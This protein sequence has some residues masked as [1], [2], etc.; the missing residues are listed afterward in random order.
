MR[1]SE[2]LWFHI[3]G[4]PEML[5]AALCWCH[6]LPFLPSPLP[7]SPPTTFLQDFSPHY[8]SPCISANHPPPTTDSRAVQSSAWRRG[9]RLHGI[10]TRGAFDPGPKGQI[11]LKDGELASCDAPPPH[12]PT[13]THTTTKDLFFHS[14]LPDLV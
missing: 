4:S 14:P 12:P 10:Q 13:N 2:G 7:C 5:Q 6:V 8:S 9:Q 11:Q 1:V 3:S